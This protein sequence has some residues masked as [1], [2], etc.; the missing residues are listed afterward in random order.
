MAR[1][2]YMQL[3][4]GDVVQYVELMPVPPNGYEVRI[5][6]MEIGGPPR[7]L[8]E[9]TIH[10][11][12]EEAHHY[13]VASCKKLLDLADEGR[14]FHPTPVNQGQGDMIDLTEAEEQ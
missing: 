8:T 3:R 1:R 14:K 6:E 12:S 10:P 9:T 7:S 13:F 11:S 5:N 2:Q 4:V